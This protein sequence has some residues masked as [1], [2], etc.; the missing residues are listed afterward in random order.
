MRKFILFCLLFWSRLVSAQTLSTPFEKSGGKKTTTYFECINFYRQ[1][2]R[3]STKIEIKKMGMSDAGY[4]YDVVLFS[5]DKKFNPVEWHRQKKIVLL[6]I[7]GIH[8][9]EPDGIDA[10]MM[11]LRDLNADKI[12]MP[13][14]VAIAVIPIYNIGGAL[15]RNSFSRVN[16]DG[17]ES[18]GFRGNSQNLD[19]N[20]DFI[21]N[22]S[23][24]AKSFVQLFQWLQPD[25][26]LDNHVSDGADFQHTITLI[27]T[28]WNKL[29]GETGKFQH[30]IFDPAL[31]SGMEKKQWPMCPYVNF[32]DRDIENGWTAFYDPP[33][34]STGYASLFHT[35][36]YM[37]ET[38]M[39][40]PFSDRVRSDY[41]LMQ[42]LIEQS[43]IHAIEI[44]ERRKRD[45]ES[46][47]QQTKFALAWKPENDKYDSVLFRGYTASYKPSDITG[48]QRLYYDRQKPFV[49]M[50]K[51]YNY[52]SGEQW[53]DVPKAYLV[54]QGWSD[55]IDRLKN[56]GVKVKQMPTDTM[57]SVEAYH[58]D[59]YQS[60]ADPFEKH[61]R[62]S[63]V[64]VSA[65]TQLLQFLKGDYIV[66]TNQPSRR[67]IVEMLEPVGEDSYFSWNFFDAV[68]QQKE[69]YSD[70]RWED[71]ASEYLKSHP[72]VKNKLEEKKKS[73][74]A[75]AR[76]AAAQLNFIY[77]NSPYYEPAH[78]RYPVYKMLNK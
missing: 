55:V 68:L 59:A 54:P 39:L 45:F 65:S 49:K 69:D 22:D 31:F 47:Q 18:Y 67:F 62:N 71:V 29:G 19:L 25:I 53:V 21:K 26:Q 34:Y 1:L 14:N 40:K 35:I 36:S 11:F 77:K 58:I 7:N 50:V 78:L 76:N 51:F 52:F 60:A 10:T 64:K 56:N 17:P 32:E 57:I 44:I 23:K 41:A 13:D 15:N 48:Q 16:Q 70:Y 73:D 6:I 30:E 46:D 61:H 33:R 2:D 27:S 24:D 37:V 75:F 74:T 9:G 3:L 28:Q 66:Y 72:D 20:R 42:T 5:N 8:P 63:Q 38:H 4:A 43:S 12:R